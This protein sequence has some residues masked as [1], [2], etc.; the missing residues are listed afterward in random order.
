MFGDMKP[1]FNAAMKLLR[2]QYETQIEACN[3]SIAS[4]QRKIKKHKSMLAYFSALEKEMAKEPKPFAPIRLN[5]AQ[6]KAYKAAQK[7][8]EFPLVVGSAPVPARIAR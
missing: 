6:R 8:G 5:R 2:D 4:L 1:F 7:R 3:E